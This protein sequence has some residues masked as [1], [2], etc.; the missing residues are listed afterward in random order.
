[1]VFAGSY[2]PN[3]AELFEGLTDWRLTTALQKF[4][5]ITLDS[6]LV[7]FQTK[8]R[9]NIDGLRALRI[10]IPVVLMTTLILLRQYEIE[11]LWFIPWFLGFAIM[12][13]GASSVCPMLLFLRWAGF[14]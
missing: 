3:R 14:R 9:I 2:Y 5:K 11:V 6:G 12:G 13:A 10:L 7:V 1:V 4:R 8:N